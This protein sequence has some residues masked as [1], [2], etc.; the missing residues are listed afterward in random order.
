LISNRRAPAKIWPLEC[1]ARASNF[2]R[3]RFRNHKFL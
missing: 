3:P 2:R 1:G